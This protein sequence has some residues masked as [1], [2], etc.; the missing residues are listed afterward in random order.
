MGR[1]YGHALA[2][3]RVLRFDGASA[4]RVL[5]FD[6]ACGHEGCGGRLRRQFLE[7][8]TTGLRPWENMQTALA[9]DKNAPLLVLTHH[10]SPGGGTFPA[11]KY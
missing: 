7:N 9:G 1:L 10:L 11:A 2:G 5:K 3:V 8:H 6:M 4:P